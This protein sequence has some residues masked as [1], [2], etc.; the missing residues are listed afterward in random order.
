MRTDKNPTMPVN[1]IRLS[2][3]SRP[4]KNARGSPTK[5]RLRSA[6][7]SPSGINGP[8]ARITAPTAPSAAIHG[9]RPGRPPAPAIRSVVRKTMTPRTPIA[10][11]RNH[12]RSR[13]IARVKPLMSAPVLRV[14][15]SALWIGTST[16]PM[17]IAAHPAN[18]SP[19]PPAMPA[20]DRSPKQLS[21]PPTSITAAPTNP[22]TGRFVP[23]SSSARIPTLIPSTGRL[24]RMSITSATLAISVATIVRN[25]NTNDARSRN[26]SAGGTVYSWTSSTP[27]NSGAPNC[28]G[29][30][31]VSPSPRGSRPDG[32][33]QRCR[34]IVRGHRCCRRW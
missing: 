17:V 9:L 22:A 24:V 20:P 18:A 16:S 2:S 12:P 26:P 32:G 29:S 30:S 25:P 8:A 14:M 10:R 13:V 1:A 27:S 15:P 23:K 33:G 28:S 21:S 34:R 4:A 3:T 7:A 31:S 19:A 11:I 5:P 6:V